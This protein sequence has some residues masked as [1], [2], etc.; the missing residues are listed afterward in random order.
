M[1]WKRLS[2][3]ADLE[4]QQLA[5]LILAELKTLAPATFQDFPDPSEMTTE[6]K[7][8]QQEENRQN[9]S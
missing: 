9:D 5:R 6:I 3:A 4:I 2:P 7:T 1:L 8:T